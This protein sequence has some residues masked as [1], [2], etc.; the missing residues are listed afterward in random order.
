MYTF[1]DL[2]VYQTKTTVHIECNIKI[3]IQ[4]GKHQSSNNEFG[5]VNGSR[6]SMTYQKVYHPF[7]KYLRRAMKMFV[8]IYVSMYIPTYIH[9]SSLSEKLSK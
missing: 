9:R 5:N 2:S 4:C 7:F 8:Y 3:I 6:K 1:E